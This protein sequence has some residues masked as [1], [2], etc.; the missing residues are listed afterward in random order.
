[1]IA[2]LAPYRVPPEA[3]AP[4]IEEIVVVARARSRWP[5]R[6][7]N[8]RAEFFFVNTSSGDGLSLVIGDDC[9][10]TPPIELERPPSEDPE[11]LDVHLLQV[12]GPQERG[13]VEALFGQVVRCDPSS[14]E[15]LSFDGD[16]VPSSPD[17]W[18]R[19]LLVAPNAGV[20][21]F[22]VA[23]DRAALEHSLHKFSARC[24]RVDDYDEVAYRFWRDRV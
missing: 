14:V 11:E 1:M 3:V 21:A 22:A 23:S 2:R 4:L 12:G 24:T 5:A 15:D 16:A 13:V 10:V 18:A 20:V 8:R 9:A 17:V 7:T 19:G 6:R